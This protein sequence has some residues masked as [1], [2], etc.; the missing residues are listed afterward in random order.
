MMHQPNDQEA[1]PTGLDIPPADWQ[2][3]PPSVQ[4]LVV[5]LLK[6]LDALETRLQQDSTTSHRPPS[7]RVLQ[8]QCASCETGVGTPR[9]LPRVVV[10]GIRRRAR[11]ASAPG[12]GYPLSLRPQARR[13]SREHQ[14]VFLPA[15]P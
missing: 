10:V 2:Q 1:V 9:W 13:G 14:R 8:Q 3:T 11:V 6:R 5:T 12:G 15:A 4:R 7:D